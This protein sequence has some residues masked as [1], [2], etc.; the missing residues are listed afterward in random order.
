[1]RPY[2]YARV[3][4]P[5]QSAA[6]QLDECR[7]LCRQRKWA[8]PVEW[9][10]HAVSGTKESRR[11][12]D[13]MMA[14]IRRG[15]CDV[16]VV[17]RFDR[18]ARSTKHLVMTL[19]ELRER[20][21]QFVSVHEQIDTSTSTGKLAFTIFAAVAEFER[22]L[23]RERVKSGLRRAKSDGVKL[24]RPS[25]IDDRICREAA[26]SRVLG[27]SWYAIAA[28]LDISRSV[29]QRAAQRFFERQKRPPENPVAGVS[30][31]G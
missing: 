30:V 15:K 12:L 7:Q 11:Q 29:A 27:M 5:Q 3:S 18:F 24:G 21:V 8:A 19:D 6:M 4:T 10:D 16:L 25:L 20:G 22:E 28:E 17:Y 2:V 26:N 13:E 14:A 1:M 31:S 23:I 9:V